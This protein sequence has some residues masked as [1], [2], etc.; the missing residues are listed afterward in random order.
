MR[1]NLNMADNACGIVDVVDFEVQDFVTRDLLFSV[2]YATSVSF[3]TS[4]ES[5]D[6]RGGIGMPVRITTHHTREANFT[7]ELPL[8]DINV[9]GVMLG[10]SGN[11]SI[12]APKSERLLV[13]A[14]S[15]KA[16]ISETPLTKR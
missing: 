5:L 9:L 2:D 1:R 7:S 12:T 3:S 6:I 15:G 14:T 4:A 8:I 13:D 10:K 16:S 11:I